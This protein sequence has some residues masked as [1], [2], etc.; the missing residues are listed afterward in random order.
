MK[1]ILPL[2]TCS[3]GLSLSWSGYAQVVA[4]ENFQT[5]IGHYLNEGTTENGNEVTLAAGTPRTVIAMTFGY[6]IDPALFAGTETLTVRF[7]KLDGALFV[8]PD[9][10]F[11]PVPG[12]G[13][14]LYNSGPQSAQTGSSQLSLTDINVTVPDTF[15]WTVEMAGGVIG[16]NELGVGGVSLYSPPTLG[17]SIYE[18]W[19][20]TGGTWE[21]W[22]YDDFP[23][24][25]GAEITVV[26]EPAAT[27][28]VLLLVAAGTVAVA[29]SKAKRTGEL[30][31]ARA[32]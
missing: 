26:P 6:Y 14:L 30:T 29:R 15:A 13:T 17:S 18:F 20:N 12:P 3:I 4:Y 1:K 25:F 24:T 10:N 19:H 32:N 11:P 22:Y 7:Y 9:P 21:L 23:T 5:D 27:A 28:V 16:R 31:L 2:L 8:D